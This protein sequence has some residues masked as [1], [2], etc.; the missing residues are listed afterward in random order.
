MLSRCTRKNIEIRWQST[1]LTKKG[2]FFNRIVLERRDY[3][4]SRAERLQNVEHW[5]SFEC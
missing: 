3:A 2:M 1:I 4:A 5:I